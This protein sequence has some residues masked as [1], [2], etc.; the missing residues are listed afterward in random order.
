MC[1]GRKRDV[2]CDRLCAACASTTMMNRKMKIKEKK[3]K[4]GN[5]KC[6]NKIWSTWHP[7]KN[8]SGLSVGQEREC[9]H[10]SVG[11]ES[12][13]T[14]SKH[15]R[16]KYSSNCWNC[17]SPNS[18]NEM[19]SKQDKIK[20]EKFA[21]NSQ[22]IE[23]TRQRFALVDLIRKTQKRKRRQVLGVCVFRCHSIRLLHTAA[24]GT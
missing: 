6:C 14:K 23:K 1:V 3:K 20:A 18:R 2:K 22:L 5:K 15:E 24:T 21:N 12:V 7:F 8:I 4:R 17:K 13:P 10:P 16:R 9:D 19:I 11:I